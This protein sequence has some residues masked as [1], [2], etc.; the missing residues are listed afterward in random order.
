MSKELEKTINKLKWYKLYSGLG[1]GTCIVNINDLETVLN[2]I[3]NSILKEK[4]EEKIEEYDIDHFIKVYTLKELSEEKKNV[5]ML[6]MHK[7]YKL[8]YC[9]MCGRKLGEEK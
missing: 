4:V 9:P 5:W 3:E 7:V 8:N 1:N 2:Y 6:Q